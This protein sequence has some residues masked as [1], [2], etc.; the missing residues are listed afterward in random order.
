M[1]VTGQQSFAQFAG[2]INQQHATAAQFA[3]AMANL[4]QAEDQFKVRQEHAARFVR[5]SFG[6]T[7]PLRT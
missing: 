2:A 5:L 1:P 6:M 7:P 4:K 3:T